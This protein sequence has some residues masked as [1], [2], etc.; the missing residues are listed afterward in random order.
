MKLRL[1]KSRDRKECTDS[2]WFLVADR[3]LHF[4]FSKC[5]R[6]CLSCSGK[7][8]GEYKNSEPGYCSVCQRAFSNITLFILFSF[9]VQ[10]TR[11]EYSQVLLVM[12]FKV[13]PPSMPRG[14]CT[15][16][17]KLLPRN[18][19]V[20]RWTCGKGLPVYDVMTLCDRNEADKGRN[21]E[22]SLV[23]ILSNLPLSPIFSSLHRLLQSGAI[24][25]R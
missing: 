9:D 13:I 10:S 20:G 22:Q 6:S 25:C 23:C 17:K 14:I 1:S 12:S 4:L 2:I 19:V 5:D 16:L 3:V 21:G 18:V 15:L 24:S 7:T 8:T 11:A